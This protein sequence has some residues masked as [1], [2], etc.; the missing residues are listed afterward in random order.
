[1]KALAILMIITAG[2]NLTGCSHFQSDTVSV[3]EQV[4]PDVRYND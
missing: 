4:P 2:A 3:G 1:M